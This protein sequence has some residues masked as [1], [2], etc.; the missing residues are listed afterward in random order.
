MADFLQSQPGF[1]VF[2]TF[3]QEFASIS[4]LLASETSQVTVFPFTDTAFQDFVDAQGISIQELIE[5]AD[6]EQLVNGL[7]FSG[8]VFDTSELTAIGTVSAHGI[9]LSV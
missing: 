7:V 2:N 5:I 4:E 6:I 1:E 9:Q 3:T 8:A